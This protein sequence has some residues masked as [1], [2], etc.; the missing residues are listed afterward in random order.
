MGKTIG[1]YEIIGELGRGTFTRS[2]KVRD[3]KLNRICV[4]HIL[5]KDAFSPEI[6]EN[7][8]QR[9]IEEAISAAKLHH[10]S[11]VKIFD[12]GECSEGPYIITEYAE[13]GSLSERLGQPFPEAE[14]ASLTAA[15]ADA[16][17]CA[18]S[19]GIVLGEI[20]PSNILFR[21][22]GTPFLS[23]FGAAGMS[24]ADSASEQAGQYALS[25]IFFELLTGHKLSPGED[26]AEALQ[27]LRDQH[28]LSDRTMQV[29][30]RSLAAVPEDRFDTLS[31]FSHAL[32]DIAAAKTEAKQGKPAGRKT[33]AIVLAGLLLAAAAAFGL[34]RSGLIPRG[35]PAAPLPTETAESVLPVPTRETTAT[36]AADAADTPAPTITYTQSPTAVPT[37]TATPTITDTFTPTATDTP[38]P[39]ETAADT[40]TPTA[41][42]T[43]TPTAANTSTPT[44][45]ETDTPTVT[46][47]FTP[48]A[49][50]TLTP[51]ATATATEIP[52][53]TPVSFSIGPHSSFYTLDDLWR[54]L[55]EN[56]G[57][58]RLLLDDIKQ[59]DGFL[60]VPE[61]KGIT[62]LILD[63]ESKHTVVCSGTRLYANGIPLT[64]GKN[65]NL[66]GM[67]I[68]GGT[69]TVGSTERSVESAS[70][71]LYG[72][73]ANLYAG[74]EVRGEG[75]Y[76]GTSSVGSAKVAIYGTVSG[77]VYGGGCAY[78]EGSE[79]HVE[80]S[81]L[82]LDKWGKVSGTLYYGGMAGSVCP[83][84]GDSCGLE[85]G[86]VTLGSV[87][88][89]IRGEVTRGVNRG[90]FSSPASELALTA[91]YA[92]YF[93]FYESEASQEQEEAPEPVL[94][95]MLIAWGQECADL[96][97][98]MTK[99][100]PETT[101]LLLRIGYNFSENYSVTLPNEGNALRSVTIDANTPVT[102]NMQN[103]SLYANGV[104]LVIG[105]NVTLQNSVIYAGGKSDGGRN[106]K[107][108]AEL[109]IAGTVGTVYAGG[110]V[111]C[112]GCSAGVGE[113]TVTISG[114]VV[115]SVYGGGYAAEK[116][117][118]AENGTTTLILTKTSRI[119]QNLYLGGQAVNYCDPLKRGTPEECDHAGTVSVGTV[120]AAVYGEVTGDIIE[121]GTGTEGA[122]ST[123]GDL[124]Y[125]EAPEA[126]MM[127]RTYPQVLRVGD[128]EAHRTLRHALQSIRYP[129][130]DVTLELC[131]KVSVTEDVVI[132]DNKA[133]RSLRLVSD[134][135]HAARI[136]DLGGRMLFA[137]GIPLTLGADI[138]VINGPVLAGGKSVSGRTEVREASLSIE[139]TVQTHVYG[140]GAANCVSSLSESCSSDA[141]DSQI[142]ISGTVQGNVYLGP[143][144][145]GSG[146]RGAVS[147]TARLTMSNSGLVRGNVYFGGNAQSGRNAELTD[148]CANNKLQMGIC[149]PES[150]NTAVTVNRAEAALYGT[151]LGTVFRSGQSGPEG[152]LSR[153]NEYAFVE[154]DPALMNLS[155]PQEL[156]VGPGELFGTL[157]QAL[158]NI[159]YS[160]NGTEVTLLLSGNQYLNE[161]IELP[162]EKNI[163]SLLITTDRPGT[164]RTIDL[165]D[166]SLFASGIP[167]TVGENIFLTNANVYAGCLL[168]VET[169][170]EAAQDARRSVSVEEAKVT[171][172]GSVGNLYAGGRAA[173]SGIGSLVGRCELD[174][175]GTVQRTVYGGGTAIN[176]GHTA[177]AETVIRLGPEA[178][179]NANIYCGG[180]A[181]ITKEK[182]IYEAE[183]LSEVGTV[184]VIDEGN[185]DPEHIFPNGLTGAGGVTSVGEIRK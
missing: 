22:D 144:T 72:S 49:T 109:V 69:Y 41:T 96:T 176:S 181:E 51:T 56:S 143:Y 65:L 83:G 46:P 3:I 171:V 39:T 145:L 104:K 162:Y 28:A 169:D 62:E 80:E 82:Y 2:C 90:S 13:G 125:I 10:S 6:Y 142:F 147:G 14:A 97:C 45:A 43:F 112:P 157:P 37:E 42:D 26:P 1:N 128:Y 74:G 31:D 85:H 184:T 58:V 12:S 136:L 127:E 47:S 23:D 86:T 139:G 92:P 84:G 119:R 108:S 185:F 117:A 98:A 103:L 64:V 94:Q 165:A 123:I 16:L 100:A 158:E 17:S 153:T 30:N 105:A 121:G 53:A 141:G 174:I 33:A 172:L 59:L 68:F 179:V 63:A 111:G 52:T 60:S 140:G 166:K 61:D 99:V 115:N 8:R 137:N 88:A 178:K 18:N 11:I 149:S 91:V 27:N 173:G 175:R 113:A 34:F 107:D 89:D 182:G 87:E 124:L 170:E 36:E 66:S 134:R 154:A 38:V 114:Y 163:R 29:L 32:Q 118:L 122:L 71:T 131:G 168:Q 159:R 9:F 160:E 24:A 57:R 132:P 148:Y 177:V 129:G 106:H 95:E 120:K 75:S 35:T 50:D 40:P 150:L 7:A 54:S 155:D 151:V 19:H 116:G 101:D 135:E 110:A 81:S 146:S 5:E 102:V 164:N 161:D 48:T 133:I 156:R 180:Y 25:L 78:G 152:T 138:T 167:L 4:M 67:T 20:S 183:S 15:I 70:L 130:G 93:D 73:A 76:Q 44:A 21:R 126:E 55:P 77:N 79:A